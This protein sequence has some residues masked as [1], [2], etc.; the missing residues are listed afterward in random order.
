VDVKLIESAGYETPSIIQSGVS[1]I[2]LEKPQAAKLLG[3]AAAMLGSPGHDQLLAAA[4]RAERMQS[5][6]APAKADPVFETSPS[7]SVPRKAV[8]FS[9]HC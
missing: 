3:Q 7:C 2:N 9:K 8:R 4:A 6:L 1:F 5:P